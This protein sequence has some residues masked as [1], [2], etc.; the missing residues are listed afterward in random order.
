MASLV[1]LGLAIAKKK[2][3]PRKKSSFATING[4][5]Q[6][7]PMPF[8]KPRYINDPP[9]LPEPLL[10]SPPGLGTTLAD[11]TYDDM[12]AIMEKLDAES[13]GNMMA[14]SKRYEDFGLRLLPSKCKPILETLNTSGRAMCDPFFSTTEIQKQCCT[15]VIYSHTQLLQDDQNKGNYRIKDGVVA[16]DRGAFS[17]FYSAKKIAIPKSV[18]FI[19]F[20][21]FF[22]CLELVEVAIPF[23]VKVIPAET[24]SGCQKLTKIDIP[25]SVTAIGEKAFEKCQK[26]QSITIPRSVTS[27]DFFAFDKCSGLEEIILPAHLQKEVYR[28][29]EFT[30]ITLVPQ[31]I[32]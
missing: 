31:S 3:G 5:S 9:G 7:R 6:S 12:L 25:A 2:F 23:G 27:I 1:E 28:P 8:K 16:I 10:E 11:L 4:G 32:F 21:A 17:Y 13:L 19:G 18:A 29:T 30:K 26:L 20:R 22:N 15:K 14:T 24:F